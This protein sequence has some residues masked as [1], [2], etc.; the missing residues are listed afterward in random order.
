V[1]K[2]LGYPTHKS[3]MAKHVIMGREFDPSKPEAYVKSFKIHSM[4]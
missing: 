3:T 2:E 4:A 1:A